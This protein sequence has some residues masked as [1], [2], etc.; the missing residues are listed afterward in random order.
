MISG[1]VPPW[2]R[3]QIGRYRN[4]VRTVI[5]APIEVAAMREFLFRAKAIPAASRIAPVRYPHRLGN[6]THEGGIFSKRKPGANSGLKKNST[7]KKT[8]AIA[9]TMRAN[10]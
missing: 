6:G 2:A 7:A 3:I 4:R 5:S 10:K 1:V 9:M 8:A